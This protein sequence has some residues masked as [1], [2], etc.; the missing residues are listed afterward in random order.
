MT[1]VVVSVQIDVFRGFV[2]EMDF[3]ITQRSLF[4]IVQVVHVSGQLLVFVA[5]CV[6]MMFL[7]AYGSLF[8]QLV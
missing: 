5:L 2:V 8:L 3:G 1:Y 4:I 7:L 6:R